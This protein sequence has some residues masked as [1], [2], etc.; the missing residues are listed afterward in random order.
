MKKLLKI[1]AVILIGLAF[2][3]WITY[4]EYISTIETLFPWLNYSGVFKQVFN[5]LVV[6]IIGGLGV[7]LWQLSGD[8]KESTNEDE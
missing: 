1:P 5:W 8:K 2:Y 6:C 7:S 3:R 4:D